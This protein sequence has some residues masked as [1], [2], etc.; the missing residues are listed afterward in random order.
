MKMN[1][2]KEDYVNKSPWLYRNI[3]GK[4]GLPLQK[5]KRVK[6]EYQELENKN[7]KRSLEEKDYLEKKIFQVKQREEY[8]KS[9]ELQFFLKNFESFEDIEPE[10]KYE[11]SK[12][13]VKKY[14]KYSHLIKVENPDEKSIPSRRK[15]STISH[16]A[17]NFVVPSLTEEKN[18]NLSKNSV[19]KTFSN[20]LINDDSKLES[21]NDINSN[22]SEEEEE[23]YQ[24]KYSG[25]INPKLETISTKS[26]KNVVKKESKAVTKII[27]VSN[28]LR[29]WTDENLSKKQIEPLEDYL[30]RSGHNIFEGKKSYRLSLPS[31]NCIKE[32]E[33][34][35]KTE[36]DKS[37]K[38]KSKRNKN[39]NEFDIL[40]NACRLMVLDSKPPMPIHV[41]EEHNTPCEYIEKIVDNL[42]V[43]IS[44]VKQA[45]NKIKYKKKSNRNKKEKIK[46][47]STTKRFQYGSWYTHPS[48]WGELKEKREQCRSIQMY[49]SSEN[50]NK[51]VMF[52]KYLE[53]P[54]SFEKNS[55]NE[56]QSD[57]E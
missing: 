3:T 38:N 41:T 18:A 10:V 5:M 23:S 30:G 46:T 22:N 24:K 25:F 12:I 51:Y 28:D 6:D 20:T 15:Y 14:P 2:N 56:S 44:K 34:E 31:I 40:L 7:I 39:Y 32:D 42:G 55:G 29:K 21:Q 13:L 8:I 47:N 54:Y 27:Q 57:N 37:T 43:E 16:I 19:T 33:K 26:K 48:R 11:V 1:L 9:I 4:K 45:K 36:E 49:P 35:E 52:H 50:W 17:N 53:C